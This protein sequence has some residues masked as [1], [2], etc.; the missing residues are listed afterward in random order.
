MLPSLIAGIGFGVL[1]EFL[2][3]EKLADGSPCVGFV[4]PAQAA[5]Q[6]HTLV[7]VALG[8]PLSRG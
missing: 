8:P 3:R 4:I 2:T 5:I 1:P 7:S 6:G